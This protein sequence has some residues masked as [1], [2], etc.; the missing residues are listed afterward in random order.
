MR[1]ILFTCVL[2]VGCGEE[3]EPVI[4]KPVVIT[5][6]QPVAPVVECL[7]FTSC[8]SDGTCRQVPNPGCT[9]SFNP[10]ITVS[11]IPNNVRIECKP[12]K[13]CNGNDCVTIPNP[14]CGPERFD[15]FINEK[16]TR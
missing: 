9:P 11:P 6:T 3:D 15:K 4:P 10:P 7:T 12:F 1:G 13:K 2:L 14:F 5:N 16:G 8:R